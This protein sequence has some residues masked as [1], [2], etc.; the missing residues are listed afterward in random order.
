MSAKS[1]SREPL[2]G[3]F[4]FTDAAEETASCARLRTEAALPAASRDA[5]NVD[6][7]SAPYTAKAYM[8][9]VNA[10]LRLTSLPIGRSPKR[11]A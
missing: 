7:Q 5:A 9:V 6:A 8:H 3:R 1:P 4:L 11:P 2:G 10:S